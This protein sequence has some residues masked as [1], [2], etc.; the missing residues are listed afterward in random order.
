[1]LTA[2]LFFYAWGEPK[3]IFMLVL[4]S[5]TNYICGLKIAAAQEAEDA[6]KA[7]AAMLVGVV[8]SLLGLGVFKYTT[9]V[10][11]SLNLLPTVHLPGWK[12]SLPIGI[13]FYTF[14][15][16]TY[17]IDVY[18]GRVQAQ[19][20]FAKFLLYISM[21]TQLIAGPIVRYVDIAAQIEG[22]AYTLSQFSSGVT[23]FLCGLGKKVLLANYAGAALNH[24]VGGGIISMT[25][26]DAWLVLVLYAFQLYFD[27][28]G[29]SDMAIGMGRMFGF[30]FLENFNYPYIAASITDFWRRWHISLSSFFRDYV[31]IPLGGNRQHHITNIV[32]VWALTGLWHGASWNFVLWG[33]YYALFLILE[34]KV[35]AEKV[36]AKLPKAFRHAYTMAVVL[37]GWGL[38]Y[39]TDF[40][41]IAA[42]VPVLFGFGRAGFFNGITRVMLMQNS[43]LLLA[44]VV[45]CTPVGMWV[46]ERLVQRVEQSQKHVADLVVSASQTV[47]NAALLFF[48]TV[49]MV[50][51]GFNP[52]LYFR[53]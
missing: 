25:T 13:S 29:Y 28:S 17:T 23:R 45:A 18:R 49:S 21:F 9:L 6:K 35:L 16:L 5:Y 53:F 1:M 27:F 31:Y 33:L 4:T 36:L 11:D 40:K 43:L 44:C 51:S 46:K 12:L 14:Q 34:K 41:D 20:S 19:Q 22:R 7:K 15:A 10:I 47:Y 42:F 26:V 52:F 37:V 2:S 38:F 30:S 8:A 24:V 48:C 3:W 32:V 39:F 50:S